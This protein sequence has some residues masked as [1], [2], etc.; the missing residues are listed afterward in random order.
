LEFDFSPEFA[1]ELEAFQSYI[2][3]HFHSEKAARNLSKIIINRLLFLKT[4][5]ELG[6]NFDERVG[7]KI[8]Q[9][10]TVR[11]IIIEKKYIVFYSVSKDR[12]FIMHL[13]SAKTD[14]LKHLDILFSRFKENR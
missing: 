14:Y 11:M 3:G 13:L 2:R 1:D 10:A 6:V 5:P 8:L 12:I 9:D 7:R 4:A